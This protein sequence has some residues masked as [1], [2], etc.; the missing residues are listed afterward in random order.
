MTMYIEL[1]TT[2]SSPITDIS[3]VGLCS[4]LWLSVDIKWMNWNAFV[5]N[6]IQL[7]VG[8]QWRYIVTIPISLT[9]LAS[10]HDS[11]LIWISRC[12]SD[13]DDLVNTGDWVYV[14]VSC[15]DG[16][17]A[18]P[19]CG[20]YILQEGEKIM[21][22]AFEGCWLENHLRWTVIISIDS[23]LELRWAWRFEIWSNINDIFNN[24]TKNWE[25]FLKNCRHGP[26]SITEYNSFTDTRSNLLESI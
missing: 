19:S 24:L 21:S 18:H 26:C 11:L 10:L 9:F 16:F 22:L 6:M 3:E 13:Y 7:V 15:F 1:L 14:V 12:I 5:H 17:V 23:Q 4:K 25:Q 20:V 2:S 8:W